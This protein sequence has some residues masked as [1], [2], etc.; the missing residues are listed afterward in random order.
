MLNID[1]ETFYSID[2]VIEGYVKSDAP[3]QTKIYGHHANA[4]SYPGKLKRNDFDLVVDVSVFPEEYLPD[5]FDRTQAQDQVTSALKYYGVHMSGGMD[6]LYQDRIG[7]VYQWIEGVYDDNH[8]TQ[9]RH[10]LFIFIFYKLIGN[11]GAE[12]PRKGEQGKQFPLQGGKWDNLSQFP[13]GD[14]NRGEAGIKDVGPG[15]SCFTT[16]AREQGFPDEADLVEKTLSRREF[17]GFERRP[18]HNAGAVQVLLEENYEGSWQEIIS[19]LRV[20]RQKYSD[21]EGNVLLHVVED[22]T[23]TLL[24]TFLKDN[25]KIK[26]SKIWLGARKLR[27]IKMLT[28]TPEERIGEA[29]S[30]I[31]GGNYVDPAEHIRFFIREQ[32]RKSV[33]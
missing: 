29:T 19:K 17:P 11:V 4:V 6:P 12:K 16:V 31:S 27:H 20:R 28:F 7:D 10:P 22:G 2:D 25:P 15:P 26:L 21:D 13:I 9:Q 24:E 30:D 5:D 3:I 1:K 8:E 32:D 18:A 33:V 23:G 14:G